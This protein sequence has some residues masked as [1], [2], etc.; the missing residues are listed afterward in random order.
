MFVDHP[1][2]SVGSRSTVETA[3]VPSCCAK[4]RLILHD[5][6]S[7]LF[8]EVD[9]VASCGQKSIHPFLLG[10]TAVVAACAGAATNVKPGA[11]V[12]MTVLAVATLTDVT[13]RR[14][15]N[16]LVVFGAVAVVVAALSTGTFHSAFIGAVVTAAPLLAIYLVSPR[17]LGGGD[18]KLAAVTGAGLGVVSPVLGVIA[19]TVAVIVLLAVSS[20]RRVSSLPMAP[21]FAVGA[22]VAL[23]LSGHGWI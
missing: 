23:F 11:V 17:L 8:A 5:Q 20:V 15:P 6:S 1:T 10:A 16:R 19:L 13:T 14:I 12:A 2:L 9:C 3:G 18:V 22:L 7:N 4:E 21:G